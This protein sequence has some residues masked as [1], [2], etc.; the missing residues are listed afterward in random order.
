MTEK[1]S[2]FPLKSRGV[3]FTAKSKV[4]GGPIL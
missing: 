2:H 1:T 3:A 4:Y